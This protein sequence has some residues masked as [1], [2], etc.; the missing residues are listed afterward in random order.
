MPCG[1]AKKIPPPLWGAGHGVGGAEA[2]GVATRWVRPGGG[3]G[4]APSLG[5]PLRA[6]LGP[7]AAEV[8]LSAGKLGP[9]PTAG[10][11]G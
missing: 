6:R 4:H 11:G 2:G 8:V 9:G 10:S 3:A 1:L 7:R 5:G